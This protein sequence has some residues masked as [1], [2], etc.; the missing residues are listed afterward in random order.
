MARKTIHRDTKKAI[1]AAKR[2]IEEVQQA[3]GNEADN[4]GVG[5][6]VLDRELRYLQI[7]PGLAAINGLSVE[8]HLGRTISEVIPDVATKVE[9]LLRGVIKTG[10]PVTVDSVRAETAASPQDRRVFIH[11]YHVVKSGDGVVVGVRCFVQEMTMRGEK[12]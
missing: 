4:V 3:D 7:S 8:A 9:P 1:N 12:G 11:S 10:K 2:M 5:S 6:C